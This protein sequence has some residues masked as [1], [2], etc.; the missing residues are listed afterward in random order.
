MG[1][2]FMVYAINGSLNYAMF[3]NITIE[4]FFISIFAIISLYVAVTVFNISINLSLIANNFIH[5]QDLT[6]PFEIFKHLGLSILTFVTLILLIFGSLHFLNKSH[7]NKKISEIKFEMDQAVKT[8]TDILDTIAKDI[9]NDTNLAQIKKCMSQIAS[10]SPYFR[11]LELVFPY[12]KTDRTVFL[13]IS[14]HR[15]YSMKDSLFSNLSSLVHYPNKPQLE[16]LKKALKNK[17]NRS[18]VFVKRPYYKIYHPIVYNDEIVYFLYS[19]Y[20]KLNS[21]SFK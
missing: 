18:E 7:T 17:D 5:A 14:Q 10:N 16:Y 4:L 20:H 6:K 8:Y 21:N 15:Y 13:E 9:E 19:S 3:S 12:N 1:I 11:N 2:W